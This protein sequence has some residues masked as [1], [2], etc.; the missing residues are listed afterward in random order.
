VIL[1]L[2][3]LP[4][5]QIYLGRPLRS[6]HDVLAVLASLS[7]Q[8]VEPDAAVVAAGGSGLRLLWSL[9]GTEHDVADRAER[10]AGDPVDPADW[11]AAIQASFGAPSRESGVRVR[12]GARATD[13]ADIWLAL[14]DLAGTEHVGPAFPMSGMAWAEL[15][16]EQLAELCTRVRALDGTWTLEHAPAETKRRYGAFGPLPTAIALLREIKRR[17]DPDRVLGP[18]RFWGGI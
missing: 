15:P 5:R 10:L 8:R 13:L 3:P 17:F 16:Q 12:L 2:R 14:E 6:I 18:G 9:A 4:P 11:D 7:A 1:R